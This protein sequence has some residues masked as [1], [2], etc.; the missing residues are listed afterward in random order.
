MKINNFL[1]G[2][3]IEW[4]L[5]ETA[6]GRII[7]AEG[8]VQG[9]KSEPFKFNPDNEH[10]ATSLDNVLYE[11]NIPPTS[12]K[13]EFLDNINYLKNYMESSLPEGLSLHQSACEFLDDEF[14]TPHA[15][16]A[17]CEAS[18]SVWNRADLPKPEL[19]KNLRTAGFHIHLSFEDTGDFFPIFEQWILAMDLFCSIP[20]ILEEP[21]SER[22]KYYGKP[23]DCRIAGAFIGGEYRALSGWWIDKAD[24]V[25][26]RTMKAIDFVNQG[27]SIDIKTDRIIY[28]AIDTQNKELAQ[29]VI[30]KYS[31]K[32]ELA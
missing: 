14:I 8:I 17:G 20:A 6:T 29:K 18:L 13:K 1:I 4:F 19:S 26:D 32:L 23:S 5:R 24:L 27:N 30:E 9:T 10:Y 3:D 31:L 7:S 21:Y 28:D 2:S 22:K 11:G 16:I 12:N 25:F 15:L